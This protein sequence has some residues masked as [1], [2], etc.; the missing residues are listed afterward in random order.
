MDRKEEVHVAAWVVG[1]YQMF[2]GCKLPIVMR[3]L[4]ILRA[5]FGV[6]V[7]ALGYVGLPSISKAGNAVLG[8]DTSRKLEPKSKIKATQM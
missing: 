4:S 2:A 5:T 3:S 6:L 8:R 1:V 7:T